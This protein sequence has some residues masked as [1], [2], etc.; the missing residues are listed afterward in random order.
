MK[1]HPYLRS[2]TTSIHRNFYKEQRSL[3]LAQ[4]NKEYMQSS[5]LFKK[6]IIVLDHTYIFCNISIYCKLIK[7][8]YSTPKD[9]AQSSLHGM[10]KKTGKF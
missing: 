5:T 8:F 1:F 9:L 3:I 4:R 2:S 10:F 7:L 6:K